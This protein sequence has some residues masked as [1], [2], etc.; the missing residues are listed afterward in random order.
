LKKEAF[1]DKF[2]QV[3]HILRITDQIADQKVPI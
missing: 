2:L 1:F 3:T